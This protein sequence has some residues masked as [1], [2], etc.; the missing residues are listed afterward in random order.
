M[1]AKNPSRLRLI[2]AGGGQDVFDVV[3]FQRTQS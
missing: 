3:I 1:N 2:V